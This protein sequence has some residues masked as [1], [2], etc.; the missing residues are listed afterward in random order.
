MLV[1]LTNPADFN[2]DHG[3]ESTFADHGKDKPRL[4][5]FPRLGSFSKNEGGMLNEH[6]RECQQS[7]KAR[8]NAQNY[9]VEENPCEC[10]CEVRD[11]STENNDD[12]GEQARRSYRETSHTSLFKKTKQKNKDVPNTTIRRSLK[13]VLNSTI[14][15]D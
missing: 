6:G 1:V 4:F 2:S 11:Q 7:E 13:A 9:R 3:G 14:F 12:E 5:F 15:K 8:R 10:V